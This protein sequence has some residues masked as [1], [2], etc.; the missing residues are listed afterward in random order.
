MVLELLTFCQ[1]GVPMPESQSRA[2]R[3]L[4]R[5]A[6]VRSWKQF[7]MDTEYCAVVEET[8]Q[9]EIIPT[10]AE[11]PGAPYFAFKP[12]DESVR[13]ARGATASALGLAIYQTLE[14]CEV[15]PAGTRGRPHP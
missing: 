14:R 9:L 13:V 11:R 3:P 8:D 2:M 10:A 4:L 15:L 1:S 5:A 12:A 6:G 7:S